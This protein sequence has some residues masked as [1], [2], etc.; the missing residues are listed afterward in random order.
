M[1][2]SAKDV[3]DRESQIKGKESQIKGKEPQY[4]PMINEADENT[5]GF[6][7]G[8]DKTAGQRLFRLLRTWA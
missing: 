2:L 7:F 8:V 5:V 1:A 6:S 4:I 3:K